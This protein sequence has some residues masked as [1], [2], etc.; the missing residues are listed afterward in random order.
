MTNTVKNLDEG[1]LYAIRNPYTGNGLIAQV[2]Q[3]FMQVDYDNLAGGSFAVGDTITGASATGIVV[4]IG[5]GYVILDHTSGAF[6]DNEVIGNG[7]GV[8]ADVDGNPVN[9]AVETSLRAEDAYTPADLE[10]VVRAVSGVEG[11]AANTVLTIAQEI[12]YTGKAGGPYTAGETVTED[13]TG[14]T[15]VV[16]ADSNL[17]ATGDGV[18][19]LSGI[20]G[21]FTGGQV[22]TGGGSGATSN[23][24][25]Y[26]DRQATFSTGTVPDQAVQVT[27]GGI[28]LSPIL[29]SGGAAKNV[30][31]ILRG[32]PDFGSTDYGI[33]VRTKTSEENPKTFDV[34]DK[35]ILQDRKRIADVV[36]TLSIGHDYVHHKEVLLSIAGTDA[37][38]IYQRQDDRAGTTTETTVFLQ[39]RNNMAKTANESEGAE[40][41]DITTDLRFERSYNLNP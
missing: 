31:E 15:G 24:G 2:A 22:L 17:T 27:I 10:V 35:G 26:T 25:V 5:T 23:G 33:Y 19:T 1:F 3:S 16:V 39:A 21:T 6:Q 14:A 40:I 11:S 36:R 38:L 28:A 41:S 34:R 12:T 4:G 29:A 32:F 7:S 8:T 20:V 13:V 37:V 9:T 18:L 30:F